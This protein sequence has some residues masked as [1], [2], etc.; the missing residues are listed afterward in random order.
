MKK[1][2]NWIFVVAVILAVSSFLSLFC[3]FSAKTDVPILKN[4]NKGYSTLDGKGT[5]DEPYLIKT[6]DD[7]MLLSESVNKGLTYEGQ[8]VAQAADIDLSGKDYVPIGIYSFGKYFLGTYD[9]MGYTISN[10][11]ISGAHGTGEKKNGNNAMFGFLGG[12]VQNVTI[13]DSTIEGSCAASIASHGGG[14]DSYIINCYSSATVRGTTRS[15]G[16]VDNYNGFV[17]ACV[18]DGEANSLCSCTCRELIGCYSNKPLINEKYFIGI[19]DNNTEFDTFGEAEISGFNENIDGYR[20]TNNYRPFNVWSYSDGEAATEPIAAEMTYGQKMSSHLIPIICVLVAAIAVAVLAG[21]KASFAKDILSAVRRAKPMHLYITIASVISVLSIIFIAENKGVIYDYLV[22]YFGGDIYADFFN[23]IDYCKNLENVYYQAPFACFPPLAYVIFYYPLSR[24]LPEDAV[25][26]FSPWK[27][28]SGIFII[29]TASIIICCLIIFWFMRYFLKK[30]GT[31]AISC[32]SILVLIS[33]CFFFGA[34][35]RG[36]SVIIVL[37]LLMA[38]MWLRDRDSKV[39]REVAL[40]LIAVAA[41]FKA[42]PALFGLLYIVEKRWKEAIRLIIYGVLFFFVPFAFC[43]GWDG[44]MQF[45]RVISQVQTDSYM[46]YTSITSTVALLAE[47]T[48]IGFFAWEHTATLA[49][50]IFLAVN[51]AALFSGKLSA[52]EK[53]MIVCCMVVLGPAWSGTYTC[54]YFAVPMVMFF[55]HTAQGFGKKGTLV[56][57]L[58]CT[59]GFATVFSLISFVNSSGESFANIRYIAIMA[60]DLVIVVRAAVFLAKKLFSKKETAPIATED[61]VEA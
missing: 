10:M 22:G 38:A 43:G 52:W 15:G 55:A 2:L 28:S 7:L 23:H 11:N 44:F 61:T 29:Y 19:A 45:V 48:N 6:V 59:V 40:I 27:N 50:A 37:A 51:A 35:E 60:I 41:G 58:F 39:A 31:G 33:N 32:V 36:N 9:G 25:I 12:R 20:K 14:K 34:I 26:R 18:F 4:P 57:N 8:Y 42:Y 46:S 49:T 53:A 5:Y 17:Y 47:E 1:G 3:V 56:Y 21:L 54:I 13:I 30:Y 16:I 24:I